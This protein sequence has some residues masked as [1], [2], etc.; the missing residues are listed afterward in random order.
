MSLEKVFTGIE[1]NGD[2]LRILF[3]ECF[4][5]ID[6]YEGQRIFCDQD[7]LRKAYRKAD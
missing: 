5:S 2:A 1:A 6:D 3:T 7:T 4:A